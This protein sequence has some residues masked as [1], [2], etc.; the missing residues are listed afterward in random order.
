MLDLDAAIIG[1]G[2]A[3]L[4]AG[5]YLTRSKMRTILLEKGPV[6]GPMINYELIENYPGFSSGISGAKL[7]SELMKQASQYGLQ[8]ESAEVK[9]ISAYSNG[10]YIDCGSGVGY[11]SKLAIIAGGSRP[12]KLGLPKE[13]FFR[14]KG[15]FHCALC[16]GNKYENKV[17]VVCGG[18]D[19]GVTE[20][21]N[22]A[23]LAS[24][25]VI[26]EAKPAL[27]CNAVLK[28]RAL[29]NSN[30]QIRCGTRVEDI[31]GS[32]HIEG[33]Q[34]LNEQG[35]EEILE[36]EGLL[37]HIGQDPN[38]DYLDDLVP[39]DPLGQIIVNAQ[40]ET[41]VP[42]ILAAGDIRA[43]SPMQISTAVGDGATAAITALKIFQQS[44]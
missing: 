16:D 42:N 33:V 22:M 3:G 8:I 13:D 10:I 35:K 4:T 1:G 40:M 23:R 20:A 37:I 25:V 18:G 38:T 39:L 24:H 27:T 43:G 15:L 29:A 17:V 36:A 32:K 12:K 21:L 7:A 41:G 31:L 2:P 34:I 26:L 9:R 5:L 11:M 19:S 14:D 44:A 28:E 30:I 6:G